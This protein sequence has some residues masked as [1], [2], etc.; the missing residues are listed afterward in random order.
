[1]RLFLSR[2]L[3]RAILYTGLASLLS[4]GISIVPRLCC[5]ELRDLN[6]LSSRLGSLPFA[7]S[8]LLSCLSMGSRATPQESTMPDL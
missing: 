8:A 6:F 3:P 4:Q 1:M 2:T 7:L 5:R